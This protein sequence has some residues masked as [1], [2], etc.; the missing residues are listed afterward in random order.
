[1]AVA[2]TLAVPDEAK[3]AVLFGLALG[4]AVA[5]GLAQQTLP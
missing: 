3:P 2:A 5:V 4:A 1:M